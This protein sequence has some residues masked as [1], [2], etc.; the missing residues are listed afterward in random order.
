MSR[1]E[2]FRYGYAMPVKERPA[3]AH[4]PI[5]AD[6][7]LRDL[8]CALHTVELEIFRYEA[9]LMS[10]SERRLGIV[11]EFQKLLV[12]RAEILDKLSSHIVK[13]LG[14]AGC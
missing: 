3:T 13:L 6:P 2:K 12:Y 5:E 1:R 9:I 8:Q 10:T 7:R 4:D 14:F 11:P